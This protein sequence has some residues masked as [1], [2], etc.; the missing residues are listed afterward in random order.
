MLLVSGNPTLIS[1]WFSG[2]STCLRGGGFYARGGICKLIDCTFTGNAATELA[3]GGGIANEAA[4]V[5]LLGCVIVDNQAVRGGGLYSESGTNTLLGCTFAENTATNGRTVACTNSIGVPS[6]LDLANCI[7]WDGSGGIWNNDGSTIQ[8]RYSDVYGGWT[9][10]GN[11]NANPLFADSAS[12][13]VRLSTGSPCIDAG[14]N[15]ALPPDEY[16]LDDDGDTCEILPADLDGNARQQDDPATIDSGYGAP[17]M[18]DMGAFEFGDDPAAGPCPGDFDG[19]RQVNLSDLATL[20]ANYGQRSGDACN[21]DMD[22]D[23]DVDLSD[24]AALLA[25]YG[26]VCD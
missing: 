24:L 9:G 1:C 26:V 21:G 12:G 14:D 25:V 22:D 19:N 13:D 5:T 11:I 17:P 23:G 18:V 7:L 8:I 3:L 10:D 6:T 15:T 20:L 2:N 4:D 16:D